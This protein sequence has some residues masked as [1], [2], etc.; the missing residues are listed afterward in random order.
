MAFE[1]F[2]Y[3]IEKLRA[4]SFLPELSNLL[5]TVRRARFPSFQLTEQNPQVLPKPDTK[6]RISYGKPD[7]LHRMLKVS[8]TPIYQ[9]RICVLN[10]FSILIGRS[11][12][13]FLRSIVSWYSLT[14]F[15]YIMNVFFSF[16]A[17]LGA[18]KTV[19]FTVLLRM[20]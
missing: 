10:W 9:F 16:W 18:A 5:R 20:H 17:Y 4:F 14:V 8:L 2:S 13:N 1:W 6:N 11:I 19:H 12:D 15:G 7:A 3:S